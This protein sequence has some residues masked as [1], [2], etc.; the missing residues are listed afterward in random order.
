MSSPLLSLLQA[1]GDQPI[2]AQVEPDPHNAQ[3][4]HMGRLASTREL[5]PVSCLI[6]VVS[7]LSRYL[8][9]RW[10]SSCRIAAALELTADGKR[11]ASE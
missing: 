3:E 9:G 10:I 8:H 6:S 2:S 11:Q 4:E 5:G 7:W 1:K